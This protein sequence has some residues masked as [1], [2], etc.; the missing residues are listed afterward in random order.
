MTENT[1]LKGR[2]LLVPPI[3]SHL[4]KFASCAKEV[5][6]QPLKHK[7]TKEKVLDVVFSSNISSEHRS[8]QSLF[9]KHFFVVLG[10]SGNYLSAYDYK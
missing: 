9:K 7:N 1:P 6:V 4:G 3:F 5:G 2:L 10:F 8:S